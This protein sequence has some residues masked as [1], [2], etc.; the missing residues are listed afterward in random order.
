MRKTFTITTTILGLILASM[1]TFTGSV[2]PTRIV[3]QDNST[4]LQIVK[5]AQKYSTISIGSKSML[6]LH[7]D[8]NKFYYSPTISMD[9]LEYDSTIINENRILF[10]DYNI[11][12]SKYIDNA[13]LQATLELSGEDEMNKALRCMIVYD[14]EKKIV[15]LE[16]NDI[17]FDGTLDSTDK[18]IQIYVWYELEDESVTIENINNAEGTDITLKLYAYVK[19]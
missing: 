6:P 11:G 2:V 3:I 4:T 12:L 18:T 14:N 15:S 7:Y 10:N 1:I 16:N 13:H 8:G 19:E 17:I 5:S 9:N